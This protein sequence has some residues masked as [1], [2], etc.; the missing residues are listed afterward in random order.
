MG[1]G[2]QTYVFPCKSLKTVSSKWT[3][4]IRLN[5]KEKLSWYGHGLEHS[6][7]PEYRAPVK[8]PAKLICGKIYPSSN[9][10]MPAK[11]QIRVTVY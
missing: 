4:I 3:C 9:I 10:I 6:R 8:S 5:R 7:W 11:Q 1:K 2:K